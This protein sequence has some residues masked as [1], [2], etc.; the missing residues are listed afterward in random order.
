[1]GIITQETGSLKKRGGQKRSSGG[2]NVAAKS[3]FHIIFLP[4]EDPTVKNQ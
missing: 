4:V 1:M 2:K 3:F